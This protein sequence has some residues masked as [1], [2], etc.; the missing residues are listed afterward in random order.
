MEEHYKTHAGVFVEAM[1]TVE[2]EKIKR[3]AKAKR[4]LEVGNLLAK[5]SEMNRQWEEGR[6]SPLKGLE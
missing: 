4:E 1:R 3:Q 6:P 5:L 2:M